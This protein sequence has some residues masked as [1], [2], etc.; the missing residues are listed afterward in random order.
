M[1]PTDGS[2]LFSPDELVRRR[3]SM[4]QLGDYN[5]ELCNVENQEIMR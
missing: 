2:I 4:L 5:H 3:L 1:I